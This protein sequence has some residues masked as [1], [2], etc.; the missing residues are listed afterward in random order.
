[1]YVVIAD[2]CQYNL[3]STDEVGEGLVMKPTMFMTNS[4][5]IARRLMRRC[6]GGHRHVHLISG[7]AAKAAE[8]TPEL[9]R[10]ICQGLVDQKRA[11]DNKV[12][13]L[14]SL[15]LAT[16]VVQAPNSAA[17]SSN[18]TA[19]RQEVNHFH[20]SAGAQHDGCGPV[21][22]NEV[23][24]GALLGRPL[25]SGLAQVKEGEHEDIG[26]GRELVN[27]GEGQMEKWLKENQEEG[28]GDAIV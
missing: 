15:T 22:M 4:I 12:V 9:C 27:G 7:R 19:C 23:G 24:L 13:M 20:G 25:K 18:C 21:K 8:Y 28:G 6:Q 1:M 2:M 10:A 17:G 11:N 16:K 3:R 26:A 5:A 14:S